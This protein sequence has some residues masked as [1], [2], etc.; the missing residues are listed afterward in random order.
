MWWWFADWTKM[1]VFTCQK[2]TQRP[3]ISLCGKSKTVLL[4]KKFPFN[5]C[6]NKYGVILL[7]VKGKNGSHRKKNGTD[8]P[9]NLETPQDAVM[10]RT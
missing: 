4:R 1:T 7:H 6:Y 10:N 8:I 2:S 5:V 9:S 3:A